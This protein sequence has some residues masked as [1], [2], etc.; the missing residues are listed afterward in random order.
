MLKM[1]LKELQSEQMSRIGELEKEVM[2]MRVK[3]SETISKLKS[4][5]L[6]EKNQCQRESD[7]KISAM[8][9]QAA[10]VSDRKSFCNWRPLVCTTQKRESV[11]KN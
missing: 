11:F 7:A 2:E 9:N 3:H 1:F 8:A 4:K 6:E 10:R 5:Y